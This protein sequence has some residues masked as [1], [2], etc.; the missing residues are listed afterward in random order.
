MEGEQN[1]ILDKAES[2]GLESQAISMS[3]PV[4]VRALVKLN[5]FIKENRIDVLCV[6]GY[7]ATVMGWLCA[8]YSKIPVLAFS[9]GYT[10]ENKKVA[11]YEW[12]DR[13]FL[14]KVDGI[15]SVSEGQRQK[16]ASLSVYVEKSWVVHNAVVVPE[17]NK[18]QNDKAK[19][20][21]QCR[22][23][24]PP[25][26]KIVVA[27][28]RLSPEKGH[29]FLV[30]AVGLL[31]NKVDDIAFFFCG[32]GPCYTNLI[33]Q[34]KELGVNDKCHFPGFQHNIQEFFQAMDLMVLP[35]LT[36][37]LPNVILEAFALAKPVVATAVGGVPELV[38][39]KENGFLVE[40]ERPDLLAEG[41]LRSLNDMTRMQDM[42]K[43]GYRLVLSEF[44]F[45]KQSVK[46]ED[47]Y[48]SL[49]KI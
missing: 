42:G 24:I 10:A 26:V 33:N 7:K 22:F 40:K 32:D 4:D 15:V 2:V 43:A 20:A 29:R 5:K 49:F 38:I 13:L 47:I 9:R 31:K 48:R 17:Q 37:G 12:L 34:A 23:D 18:V 6:H 36:E 25:G 41:I 16:L 1:E 21:I 19:Q 30:D 39:D 46:L 44:S 35:S 27:A 14:K 28:G 11:F 3:G 45:E 8:K